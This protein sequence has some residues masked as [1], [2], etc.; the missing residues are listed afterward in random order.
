M[1]FH[2]RDIKSASDSQLVAAKNKSG[3]YYLRALIAK[4]M[5]ARKHERI[6]NRFHLRL[7]REIRETIE[8]EIRRIHKC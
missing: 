5:A 7:A 3:N 8:W 6:G 1:A 4:E 2:F